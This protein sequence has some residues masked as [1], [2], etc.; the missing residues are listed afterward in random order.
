MK[1]NVLF[2]IIVIC[3]IA[4][5]A[6]D[7]ASSMEEAKYVVLKLPDFKEFIQYLSVRAIGGPILDPTDPQIN[8]SDPELAKK[9]T[10]FIHEI[11]YKTKE[12]KIKLVLMDDNRPPAIIATIEVK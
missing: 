9:G 6:N 4:G 2:F 12:D 5:C 7:Q 8:Q 11:I 1:K 10:I 3:F